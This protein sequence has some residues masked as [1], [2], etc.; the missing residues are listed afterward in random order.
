MT[1]FSRG[2]L[3][4]YSPSVEAT[5]EKKKKQLGGFLPRILYV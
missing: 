4:S 5:K 1:P 3:L 2:R